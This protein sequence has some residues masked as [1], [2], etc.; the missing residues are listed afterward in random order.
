[1][2]KK[3]TTFEEYHSEYA[4]SIQNPEAF[5]EEKAAQFTWYKKWDSVLK[6][7]FSKPEIKWFEGGKLNITENCLDRHL[8]QKSEQTA[9]KWI[10]NNPN[11]QSRCLSYKELHTEVCKFANVLKNNGAIKGDRICLYMPMVPELAIA[12]LACARIGAIHSVV[13]AGFSAKS[14][15]D[16]INDA[17]CNIL[18]TADGGFRGAKIT[19]LKDI[20]DEAMQST[21]S[22]KKCIV[23]ER[24][25]SKI[26]MQ[27][28]RDIW[29]HNEMQKVNSNFPAEIMD[30]EDPLFILYTS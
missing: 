15:S 26:A 1:M 11:E 21:P 2:N 18:I 20:S 30:S 7:D 3:I 28:G 14:L 22:I 5:W 4:K 16:R 27:N 29:W 6:W 19:P 10:A 8:E 23:L 25:K 9:I 12:V 24:T 13:F 17:D